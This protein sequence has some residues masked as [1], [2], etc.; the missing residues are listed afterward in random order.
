MLIDSWFCQRISDVETTAI[1]ADKCVIRATN[2]ETLRFSNVRYTYHT[3][4]IRCA[5]KTEVFVILEAGIGVK[6]YI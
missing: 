5:T 3:K 6:S 1:I 4:V 2:S